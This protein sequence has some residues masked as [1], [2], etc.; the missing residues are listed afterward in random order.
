FHRKEGKRGSA[1]CEARGDTI[2]L[3][4]SQ[5]GQYLV[6][7]VEE[8]LLLL[9]VA[10][11]GRHVSQRGQRV[12][13]LYLLSGPASGLQGFG[14]PVGGLFQASEGGQAGGAPGEDLH[15]LVDVAESAEGRQS[16]GEEIAG[17]AV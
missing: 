12:S 6:G 15:H 10:A 7:L 1:A 3:G 13:D 5:Q 8:A 4:N 16:V 2:G 14:G 17:G 11:G 9:V